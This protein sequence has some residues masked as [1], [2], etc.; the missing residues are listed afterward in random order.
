VKRKERAFFTRNFIFGVEDS[1]VSTVGL[2]SGV[3]AANVERGTIFLTGVILIF[4][5]A[6]SMGVGS[7]LSEQSAAEYASND[8]TPQTKN[9]AGGLVMFFS[10]FA[11]GFIPLAPYIL[12]AVSTAFWFSITFSLTALFLLGAISAKSFGHKDLFRHGIRMLAIGGLA[13]AAGVIIGKLLKSW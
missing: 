11:A 1:L 10:Y 7:F 13:I 6:L 2:L 9:I 12:L 5:E 8:K 3:A 4:V